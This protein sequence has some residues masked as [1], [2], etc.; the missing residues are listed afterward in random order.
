M[1]RYKINSLVAGTESANDPTTLPGIYSIILADHISP[2]A[3]VVF[4][5]IG[6][7]SGTLSTS[8][9]CLY[10]KMGK[11]EMVRAIIE[12]LDAEYIEAIK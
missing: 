11:P 6:H 2:E 9:L 4:L 10:L 5:A 1:S 12:L 7:H 3:K 8:G